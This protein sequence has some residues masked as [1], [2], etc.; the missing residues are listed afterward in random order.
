MSVLSMDHRDH[1]LSYE[2]NLFLDLLKNLK[3]LIDNIYITFLLSIRNR[4]LTPNRSLSYGKY[5]PVNSL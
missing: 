3:F 4:I 5:D 1:S 2:P